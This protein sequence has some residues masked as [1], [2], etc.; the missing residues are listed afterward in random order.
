MLVDPSYKDYREDPG[1][2]RSRL[3]V[4]DWAPAEGEG[5]GDKI[6]FLFDG[7]ALARDEFDAICLDA[8]ELVGYQFY[9]IAQI[10]NLTIGRLARRLVHGHAGCLD[11]T[12]RY[13]ENGER[14]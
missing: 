1:G 14:F 4:A 7:G 5:E 12:T 10:H 3:L 11:G 2:D 9:D 6:L 13:L 8:V